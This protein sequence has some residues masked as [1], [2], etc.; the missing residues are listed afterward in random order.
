M[1]FFDKLPKFLRV[2]IQKW[3][4]ID[5]NE[6]YRLTCVVKLCTLCPSIFLF[7]RR[8]VLDENVPGLKFYS[9]FFSYKRL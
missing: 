4:L 2:L 9:D 5:G 1:H 8:K 7:T 3:Q 6:F